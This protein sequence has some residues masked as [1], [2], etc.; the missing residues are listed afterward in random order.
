[1]PLYFCACLV[2]GDSSGHK[3]TLCIHM[4]DTYVLVGYSRT[5][6]IGLWYGMAMV[7]IIYEFGLRNAMLRSD[8]L[9]INTGRELQQES[10]R[11]TLS[12]FDGQLL[13]CLTLALSV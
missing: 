1:M 12:S 10:R 9:H 3:F 6:Y 4:S 2:I 8:T 11:S 5:V 13:T 7:M